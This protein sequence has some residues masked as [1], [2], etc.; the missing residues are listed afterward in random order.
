MNMAP[1]KKGGYIVLNI[2]HREKDHVTLGE[3]GLDALRLIL[4]LG[5][6]EHNRWLKERAKGKP[7]EWD[8]Y[9]RHVDKYVEQVIWAAKKITV[10]VNWDKWEKI[11]K[12]LTAENKRLNR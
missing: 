1:Q 2:A 3:E 8:E 7:S 5:R 4:G 9:L 6:R 12:E 11:E 10:E